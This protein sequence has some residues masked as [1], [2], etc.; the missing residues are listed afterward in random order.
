MIKKNLFKMTFF[1]HFHTKSNNFENIQKNVRISKKRPFL[2]ET[3]NREVPFCTSTSSGPAGQIFMLAGHATTKLDPC[4]S[5]RIVNFSKK[6]NF[7]ALSES[8]KMTFST[9]D[10]QSRHVILYVN[11][12]R[13]CRTNFHACRSRDDQTRSLFERANCQFLKKKTFGAMS[14]SQKKDLFYPGLSITTCHSVRQLPPDL[15]DKF[16]CLQ[17]TRRPNSIPV[18]ACELSISQ[19]K[20]F[21][22]KV[23]ISKKRPFLP[24]TVNHDMSFCRSTSS[25]P[26]GQIFMLAGHATTKLDPCLSVR[27]VNFSKKKTFGAKSESQKKD[28]FYPG[29]SITTCHS[30]RQL[31]PD[32]PDKFSCLQVTRR[33]NSTPVWA[34]ELS[35]S[36]KK[37]IS[38]QSQNLK[39]KTFST[40][41]CQSQHVILYV[42]FLRTC[43]TNF[44][45]C[46]SRDDQTRPLFERANCQF[47]KKNEFRRIVRISKKDLF[48]PGLSITT[49]HSVRQLPPDLPD[50][51]SCLQVTRRPNSTPVWACE[52]SISQKKWISVQMSESQKK[53]L[54][55][56]GLSITTCHSVR[57]LP[58]DLPDKFSCL[59]VTRRPNSTPVWACELSI[60][61]KKWIST[62]C[63]NLKKWPFLPGTVNHDMSFCTS[64]SSG[65]AGQI[66]ML[67]Y[68]NFLRACRTNFHVGHA[69]TKL[70]PCLS[71]RIVNFSKKW[72]FVSE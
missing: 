6:M 63:Q 57:Q 70:D 1:P 31:P 43:R 18:W 50:K 36:Q 33:P 32:L 28:L 35:I 72:L 17:V 54:F 12:L 16:S 37:W 45:A 24:G 13:T 27:I 71:V 34:C 44:H 23:R 46:R 68:V 59:Q 60:S 61:Q 67:L 19:K 49:C 38:V 39:K 58:P 8:Q 62:H 9:R 4:L 64:T 52:L 48:Y 3:V 69:T 7:D 40:R 66:F 11:F 51:F 29:L 65:P 22:C 53:D 55:Y 30:V 56:P 10:C 20:D 25:G 15:S 26:A 47:L 41:D 14:E 42:N 2:P 5:V 21:R